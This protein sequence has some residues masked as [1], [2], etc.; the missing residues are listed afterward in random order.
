MARPA[1]EPPAGRAA[2]E[3]STP[4]GGAAAVREVQLVPVGACPRALA[5]ALAARLSRHVS[6]ACRVVAGV[7][8]SDLPGLPGRDQLDAHALVDRVAR[9]HGEVATGIVRLGLTTRDIGLSVFTFVFGLA[10]T[11]DGHAAVVSLARLDPAF[12]G[13]PPD[14]DATARRTVGVMLH[15]LGHVAGLPHCV[16]AACLMRFAGTLEKADARGLVFC[17]ACRARLPVWLHPRG[18]SGVLQPDR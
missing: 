5:D 13:L 12:Y 3:R 17:E 10:R 15:E 8:V 16:E 6:A 2:C 11:D 7:S 4:G 1:H 9:T 14:P 18:A